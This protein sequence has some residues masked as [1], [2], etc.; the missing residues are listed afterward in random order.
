MDEHDKP[1]LLALY[2]RHPLTENALLRRLTDRAGLLTEF[3]LAIDRESE[4]T[5][6]NHIGGFRSTIALAELAE[7]NRDDRVIDMGCGLGGPARVLASI[8][9]CS[10]HGVDLNPQRIRQAQSLSARVGLRHLVSFEV[11]DIQHC[12]GESRYSLL[13]AQ[14]S[15][16]HFADPQLFAVVA[17]ELLAPR[18]RVA[19]EDVC[20]TRECVNQSER[21]SLERLSELWSCHLRPPEHWL[22]GI[23]GAGFTRVVWEDARVAMI[24]YLERISRMVVSPTNEVP[25]SE[26]EG[27]RLGLD[28]ARTGLISYVRF[29]GS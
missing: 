8:Y 13:W 28:L 21:N 23:K 4:L 14:N 11:N 24:A 2:K 19:F 10:V 1:S 9:G 18:A 22:A 3:D 12:A 16:T 27:W 15:W 5:D 25:E 7:V 20:L 6:Q 26:I 29:A 17:A